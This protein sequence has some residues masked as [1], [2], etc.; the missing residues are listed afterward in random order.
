MVPACSTASAVLSRPGARHR[1][2][3]TVAPRKPTAA[4]SA[5]PIGTHA[6]LRRRR[7]AAVEGDGATTANTECDNDE[8]IPDIE[9]PERPDHVRLVDGFLPAADAGALRAVFDGHNDD[10]RRTHEYRFVWDY[11]HVPG[12]YTQLRTPAAD[13]FPKEQF[14]KLEA[15]LLT[16]ARTELGCSALT[17]VWLSNYVDGMRQEIHADVPNGP[18]AFVLSLTDWDERKFSGGETF[19]LRPE[20][21]DYWRGFDAA[22][23]VE[24][25]NIVRTIEPKFNRMTVF[26]PRIPHGVN[27]V[28]GTRDP[29]EGRLVL[30]GWF[31]D[32]APHFSGALT[33]ESC[34]ES[35][36]E[37]LPP[38]YAALAE[39]P[40]ALGVVVIRVNVNADGSVSGTEWKADTLVPVPAPDLPDP[41]EVR[42]AILLEI[43]GA[44][45]DATFPAL[46]GSITMPFEFD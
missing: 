11:W 31:R 25:E 29:R 46:S 13:Y 38:L 23:V 41:T 36:G 20:S 24:R 22:D 7:V 10:P 16:Y 35:L 39:L 21:L 9:I 26:D 15:S 4:K 42:D 17:P 27:T 32:L 43:A 19:M 37:I 33:E 34:E 2:R 18:W 6:K 1:G 8:E 3:I 45:M 40:R 30:H 44:F 12:Q 5:F 28:G 14:D